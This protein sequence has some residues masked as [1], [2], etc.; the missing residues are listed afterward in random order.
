MM[1]WTFLYGRAVVLDELELVTKQRLV[2]PSFFCQIWRSI[3]SNFAA[4][5]SMSPSTSQTRFFQPVRV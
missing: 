1:K 5:I 2:F 4:V 3:A